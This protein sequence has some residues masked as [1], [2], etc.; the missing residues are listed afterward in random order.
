[1]RTDPK[2]QKLDKFLSSTPDPNLSNLK[3]FNDSPSRLVAL[4]DN[5][6]AVVAMDYEKETSLAQSNGVEITTT[7]GSVPG[8]SGAAP[9]R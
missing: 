6:S 4:D 7:T 2:V 9:P 5:S 1:M 3:S 8:P